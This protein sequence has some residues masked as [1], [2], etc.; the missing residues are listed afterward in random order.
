M[1][2]LLREAQTT[3]GCV[4]VL[5]GIANTTVVLR[6]SPLPHYDRRSLRTALPSTLLKVLQ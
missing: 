3:T 6:L 1:P 4:V 5:G 2:V